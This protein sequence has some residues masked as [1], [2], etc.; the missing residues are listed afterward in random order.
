MSFCFEGFFFLFD[1]EEDCVS[2]DDERPRPIEERPLIDPRDEDEATDE[3]R[4]RPRDAEEVLGPWQFRMYDHI[5][6]PIG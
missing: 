6:A 3:E 5:P 4:L 1:M 2:L